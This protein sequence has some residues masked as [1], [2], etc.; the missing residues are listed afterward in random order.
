MWRQSKLIFKDQ[1][2]CAQRKC[3]NYVQR[4]DEFRS[5]FEAREREQKHHQEV[6][7]MQNLELVQSLVQTSTK[8]NQEHL[9]QIKALSEE[10]LMLREK[11][12]ER[13]KVSQFINNSMASEQSEAI[14]EVR[15]K[16]TFL[17]GSL[18][19]KENLLDKAALSLDRGE[20][21]VM[22]FEDS[23]ALQNRTTLQCTLRKQ[24]PSWAPVPVHFQRFGL[25]HLL[26]HRP[27]ASTAAAFQAAA[28]FLMRNEI[29]STEIILTG[30][31]PLPTEEH[32]SVPVD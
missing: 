23:R 1:L 29:S 6:T 9:N 22:Q 16:N 3:R 32:N 17:H 14:H 15:M 13:R 30:R 18:H 31:N 7:V 2:Y 19:D 25:P 5:A 12:I 8:Q 27:A 4:Y 26:F 11:L 20:S 24:N 10:K 21:Q 28:P